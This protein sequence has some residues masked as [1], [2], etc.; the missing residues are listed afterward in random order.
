MPAG[1]VM[2]AGDSTQS[3]LKSMVILFLIY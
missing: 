3:I 2:H 1:T